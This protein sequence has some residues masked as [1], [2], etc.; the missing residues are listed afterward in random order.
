M[1][2]GSVSPAARRSKNPV[3][4]TTFIDTFM[5]GWEGLP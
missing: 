1:K 3:V 4:S 2:K 5:Q